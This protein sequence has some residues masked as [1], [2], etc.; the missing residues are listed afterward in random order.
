MLLS[1]AVIILIKPLGTTKYKP[2]SNELDVTP[3]LEIIQI[4]I[5]I[6]IKEVKYEKIKIW[7]KH[8]DGK[9]FF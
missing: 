2:Q 3:S 4:F 1:C 7:F 5:I 9:M 6:K 8:R